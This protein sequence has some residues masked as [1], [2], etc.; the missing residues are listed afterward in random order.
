M[1]GLTASQPRGVLEGV[2]RENLPLAFRSEAVCQERRIRAGH[3]GFRV[4]LA[5]L[6]AGDGSRHGDV[7]RVIL[8]RY[9]IP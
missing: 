6:D 1:D 3:P 9:C 4:V 2:N 7:G 5:D 8:A